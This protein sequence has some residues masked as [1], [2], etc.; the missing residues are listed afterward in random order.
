MELARAIATNIASSILF[1]SLEKGVN[2]ARN[3]MADKLKDGDIEDLHDIKT[4]IDGLSRNDLLTSCSLLT[5]GIGALKLI[6]LE[7]N[8][9]HN[10]ENETTAATQTNESESGDLNEAIALSTDIEKLNDPSNGL[11]VS[12]EKYFKAARE[13]ATRAFWNEALSLTDRIMAAK[14]RVASKIFECLQDPKV[15]AAG[16]VQFLEELHK[17]PAIGETFSTYFKGEIKSKVYKDSRLENV[18]SVLSLNFAI[19]KFVAKFSGEL[20]NVL[21]NWPRIHLSTRETIHPLLLDVDVV[22][23]IFDKEEFQ[24]PEN[25]ITS[26]RL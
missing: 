21:R 25:Q 26:S 6:K 24:P 13:E 11:L 10:T 17:L 20:P 5:E 9:D 15:A 14:I 1:S 2:A 3:R 18:K 23:D 8:V 12:T 7:E 19:S 16:C 4:K 22:K